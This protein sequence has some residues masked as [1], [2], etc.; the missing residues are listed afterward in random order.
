VKLAEQRAHEGIVRLSD[1]IK[2]RE[3]SKVG[4]KGGDAKGNGAKGNGANGNGKKSDAPKNGDSK[5]SDSKKAKA[6]DAEEHDPQVEEAVEVL[7]D[8]VALTHRGAGAEA[9][10]RGG[11]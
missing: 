7:A 8:L 11:Q 3:E 2:E 6:D 5:N 10:A 4:D 1:I 9:V